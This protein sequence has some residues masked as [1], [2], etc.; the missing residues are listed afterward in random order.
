MRFKQILRRDA[1]RDGIPQ[2]NIPAPEKVPYRVE[3]GRSCIL[4]TNKISRN[5]QFCQEKSAS[6]CYLKIIKNIT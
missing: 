1:L 4:C 2:E 6:Y 5:K 3:A